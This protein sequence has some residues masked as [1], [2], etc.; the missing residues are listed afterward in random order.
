MSAS[1]VRCREAVED[2]HRQR[3]RFIRLRCATAQPLP[4][5]LTFEQLRD[6]ISM[7]VVG[8]DVEN[9]KDVRVGKRSDCARLPFESCEGVATVAHRV[10]EHL[11]SHHTPEP[12]IVRAVN[13]SHPAGAERRNDAV[14]TK[15]RAHRQA[16]GETSVVL[17]VDAVCA[18]RAALRRD[19][20]TSRE[21]AACAS[22][23]EN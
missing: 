1:D 10:G 16:H 19:T 11:H 5:R 6:G 17:R 14:R 23:K 21:A 9:R 3:D 2:L 7:P 18:R 8:A 20:N 12:L 13:L 22:A 15:T 4:E